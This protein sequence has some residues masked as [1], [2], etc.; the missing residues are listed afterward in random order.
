MSTISLKR[1]LSRSRLLKENFFR[2]LVSLSILFALGFIVFVV[3]IL[4]LQSRGALN[5]DLFRN[6]PS[7]RPQN[8]GIQSALFGSIWVVGI[9]ALVAVPVGVIAA[10]FLEEFINPNNRIAKII[11]LNVRNL[12][13]V[14]AVVFGMVGLAFIARGPFGWGF[15]V[16]T[17]AL[18]LAMM[19]LP[20]V[21]IVSRE[22]IRAV[23]SSLRDGSLALGATQ[24]QTVWRTVMP[25]A[26]PSISTGAILSVSRAMGESA[27][28][29]LLGAL[30]FVTFNP[31]SLDSDYT[32]L[33]LIIFRYAS[34]AKEEFHAIAAAT[35]LVLMAIL[36]LMNLT[37]ILIRDRSQR[38]A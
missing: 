21:I 29:L 33:P 15:T 5:L 23:P 6:F 20:V 31:E 7:A 3:F 1:N 12:A 11:D 14:P 32:V 8:A 17:A 26:L 19:I 34:D 24:W 16:G 30:A 4:F 2:G 37:A 9:A 28:L 25:S 36:F 35:S 10:V 27:P 38:K 18:V 22:S 13:G